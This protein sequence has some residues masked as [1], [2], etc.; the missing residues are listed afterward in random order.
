MRIAVIDGQ[1]GGVGAALVE[2]LK[3]KGHTII[4]LGTN[5]LAT[6]AML[7]AGAGEGATGENAICHCAAQCDVITGPIGIVAANAL[8][9]EVTPGMA[10]AVASSPAPKILVPSQKCSIQIAGMRKLPLSG[11]VDEAVALIDAI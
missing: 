1:G 5:A 10:A 6:S 3:N 7:R 11:Y 9:G 2:R 8:L 4:A